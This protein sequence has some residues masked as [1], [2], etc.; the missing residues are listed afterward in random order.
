MQIIVIDMVFSLD[1]MK[2]PAKAGA[3]L[4]MKDRPGK[5]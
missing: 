2:A 4:P 3:V 1:S 5:P